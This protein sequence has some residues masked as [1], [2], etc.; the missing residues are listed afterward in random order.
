MYT[1]T[2]LNSLHN[3]SCRAA[4]D[5]GVNNVFNHTSMTPILTNTHTQTHIHKDSYLSLPQRPTQGCPNPVSMAVR[6]CVCGGCHMGLYGWDGMPHGPGP[7]KSLVHTHRHTHKPQR[8]LGCVGRQC[9]RD[10]LRQI[11]VHYHLLGDWNSRRESHGARHTE[12]KR[13]T[14]TRGCTALPA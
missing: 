2:H 6:E 8:L 10:T 3:F 4:G 12:R 9:V 13:E 11:E 5:R 7:Q 1:H 14:E